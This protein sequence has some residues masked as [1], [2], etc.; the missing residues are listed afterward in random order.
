MAVISEEQS[1]YHFNLAQNLKANAALRTSLLELMDCESGQS[2]PVT[3]MPISP[4]EQAPSDPF[5]PA[6]LRQLLNRV[7]FPG[8]HSEGYV[9][10]YSTPRIVFRKEITCIGDDPY[11]IE[12]NLGKGTY[13]QVFKATDTRTNQTVALKMQ[14]P[15]NCWEFYICRELQARLEKHPLKE[16]FMDVRT[17]YFSKFEVLFCLTELIDVIFL[18]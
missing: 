1:S 11:L 5:K 17:G 13:G 8:R 12:K 18:L 10:I 7:G 9:K 4:L 16:C 3:E 14:K 6:L 2:S 15:P